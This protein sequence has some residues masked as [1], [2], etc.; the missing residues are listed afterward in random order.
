MT[1]KIKMKDLEVWLEDNLSLQ[2]ILENGIK[3]MSIMFW[4]FNKDFINLIR[5][6]KILYLRTNRSKLAEGHTQLATKWW[7]YLKDNNWWSWENT[8]NK[9]KLCRVELLTC[10]DIALR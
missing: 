2:Q 6:Y 8:K 4:L 7:I 10:R 1:W 3:I 9:S 5:D